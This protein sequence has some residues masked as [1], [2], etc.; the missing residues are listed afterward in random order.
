MCIIANIFVQ[1]MFDNALDET[2]F[3]SKPCL[4]LY[5]TSAQQKL[6]LDDLSPD[7]LCRHL[8]ST[9]TEYLDRDCPVR[10][11][12]IPEDTPSFDDQ[13]KT[14]VNERHGHLR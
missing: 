13:V 6:Y 8:M 7:D 2:V 9:V 14:L 11:F 1:A 12:H 3:L 5:R 10:E 4:S